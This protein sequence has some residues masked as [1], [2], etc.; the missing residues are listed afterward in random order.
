MQHAA[1][2]EPTRDIDSGDYNQKVKEIR[3]RFF[4]PK[5]S[6]T[7]LQSYPSQSSTQDE[8]SDRQNQTS[9]SA[10]PRLLSESNIAGGQQG[11]YRAM[12][13]DNTGDDS[14]SAEARKSKRELS[15]SKRAAQNRAAQR[16][17]RQRKEGYIRELEE[18]VKQ[19]E[20]METNF[21]SLQEENHQ[22]REYILGLQS[23]LL[24]HGREPPSSAPQSKARA[25]HSD[26]AEHE[27]SHG[28]HRH[29]ALSPPNPDGA[30]VTQ[31]EDGASGASWSDHIDQLRQRYPGYGTTGESAPH[32]TYAEGEAAH[33][34]DSKPAPR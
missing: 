30:S 23:Q 9:G 7:P 11:S 14:L 10:S 1:A 5:P 12:S 27:H 17:F 34:A 18:K 13:N 32:R 2:Q 21:R 15:T 19:F 26:G 8:V 22:L 6:D 25:A 31:R 29:T 4:G 3:D 20:S 24:E 33:S 16:A 28:A